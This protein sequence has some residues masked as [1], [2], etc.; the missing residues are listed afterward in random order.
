MSQLSERPAVREMSESASVLTVAASNDLSL[1]GSL[2]FAARTCDAEELVGHWEENLRER[3][4]PRGVMCRWEREHT[5]VKG[6]KGEL[7]LD[8]QGLPRLRGFTV[9]APKIG[10]AC[11]AQTLDGKPLVTIHAAQQALANLEAEHGVRLGRGVKQSLPINPLEPTFGALVKRM[12]AS[13]PATR[14][15]NTRVEVLTRLIRRGLYAPNTRYD[16]RTMKEWKADYKTVC[17]A[18]KLSGGNHKPCFDR[19]G[20][21]IR[22]RLSSAN[23]EWDAVGFALEFAI[24]EGSLTTANLPREIKQ[25]RPR[26]KPSGPKPL[27]LGSARNVEL[28]AKKVAEMARRCVRE[29]KAFHLSDVRARAWSQLGEAFTMVS[30]SLVLPDGRTLTI[31]IGVA[32]LF[33]APVV[34]LPGHERYFAAALEAMVLIVYGLAPRLG[35]LLALTAA[36]TSMDQQ[37]ITW[38]ARRLTTGRTMYLAGRAIPQIEEGTKSSEEDDPISREQFFRPEIRDALQR[39][40]A[41]RMALLANG[42]P[43]PRFKGSELLFPGLTGMAM[44]HGVCERLIY[45]MQTMA[46]VDHC[47]P[48]RARHGVHKLHAQGGIGFEETAAQLGQAVAT[49]FR[50]YLLATSEGREEAVDLSAV[51]RAMVDQ[52]L[53]PSEIKALLRGGVGHGPAPKPWSGFFQQRVAS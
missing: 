32:E 36:A 20:K 8:A 4:L 10:G 33:G 40:Y 43:F 26:G 30:D 11:Q 13:L 44:T 18:T 35:E 3:G 34:R 15:S 39:W 17:S 29:G 21:P 23:Q 22:R 25:R 45:Q 48:H 51:A 5:G 31:E 9:F 6:V 12:E 27:S 37:E 1:P 41:D 49:A 19:N 2:A 46:G 42:F 14:Q 7:R 16:I 28:V 38:G 47:W 24:D 53:S 52:G 50:Y